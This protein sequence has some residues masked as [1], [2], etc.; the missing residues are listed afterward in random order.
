VTTKAVIT[1]NKAKRSK[2]SLLVWLR[3]LACE[4][5]IEQHIRAKLRRTFKTIAKQHENWIAEIFISFSPTH[6]DK[7]NSM[8]TK[9][10]ES[11]KKI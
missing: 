7:L 3:L 10:Y 6:V 5:I 1:N 11:L 2:Q 9:T 4:S 8:L